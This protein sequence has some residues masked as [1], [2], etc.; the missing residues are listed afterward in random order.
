MNIKSHSPNSAEIISEKVVI[1]ELEDALQLLGDIYYQG[2]DKLILHAH[3][4]CPQFYD[5]RTGLAGEIIQKF[6]QYRMGLRIV[7]D[8]TTYQSKSLQAFM[9]ESNK[10]KHL[11]F[12]TSVEE[13]LRT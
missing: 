1:T 6:V 8:F 10:G 4:F 11:R 2:F 3:H 7:G 5:L 12:V 13:A 9:F